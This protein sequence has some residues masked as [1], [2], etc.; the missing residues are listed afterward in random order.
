MPN[1]GVI[2]PEFFQFCMQMQYYVYNQQRY[3]YCF[4]KI[5]DSVLFS[6][7]IVGGNI[8][9]KLF[10]FV[11]QASHLSAIRKIV[12]NIYKVCFGTTTAFLI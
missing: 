11:H 9:K 2:L 1:I 3:S 8:C 10:S 5:F 7:D 12:P 4:T 6:L